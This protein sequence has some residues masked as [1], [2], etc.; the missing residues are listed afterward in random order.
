MSRMDRGEIDFILDGLLDLD[1]LLSRPRFSH[2]DRDA[3]SQVLDTAAGLADDKFGPHY[4]EADKHEPDRI[5]GK[6]VML[7]AVQEAVDAFAEAGFLA[8]HHDEELGGLQLPWCVVQAAFSFFQTANIATAAYPFL[9]IGAGNLIRSFGSEA[10]QAK[11]LAP[12]LTGRFFGTMALSEPQAGSSLADIRTSA[13]PNPDGSYAITGTKQWISAGEHELS[14]NIVHMVLAK[15]KGAPAGVKGISL[16]IVPRIRVNDDGSL[17]PDNDVR[18]V[19]LLH[20]MGYRGTTSTI[21]SFGEEGRCQG[22][23]VGQAHHGLSYMFQMMN[24]ARIGVGLGAA[25]LGYAGYRY[26]AEYARTRPQGRPL[27]AR[28]PT[29]PMVPIIEHADVRRMLL[30]QKAAS[31]G[32]IALCLLCARLVDEERTAAEEADRRRASLLLELLTPIAKSW[33]SE[34]CL[35][36]NKWAI[37][38]LGGYGYTRDYPV[39]QYYRDNRLNPIHEG[40]YGIQANDLLGRK[41]FMDGGAAFE[42]LAAE[43]A[44][45]ITAATSRP[46]LATHAAGLGEALSRVATVTAHL[47]TV[48]AGGHVALSLANATTYLEMFG[49]TVMAWIWLR[50]ALVADTW[51]TDGKG[52]SNHLNGKLAACRWFFA[53]ELPKTVTQATILTSLDRTVLDV[54]TAWL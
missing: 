51:L 39:E 21:L 10:Q 46:A 35:E 3:L 18:L 27:E 26:S 33:P 23:L 52:D 15:I 9:T 22:F 12:M 44:T 43:M 37:Q 32:A 4:H 36:A 17:G 11:F 41:V 45:T 13:T 20:K 38:I 29:S 42:A 5:N 47:G 49:H 1:S 8:A 16:F 31:E 53:H 14:D 19:S 48:R 2:L 6:V 40:T 50:Q 28:D 25:A 30:Q 24:E 34:H 7:P 54:D